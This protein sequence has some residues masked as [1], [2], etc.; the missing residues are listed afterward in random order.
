MILSMSRRIAFGCGRRGEV[1]HPWS[2]KPPWIS[3][4]CLR[5][6][7]PTAYFGVVGGG[8]LPVY[9]NHTQIVISPWV[10]FHVFIFSMS[11]MIEAINVECHY[12][13]NWFRFL[14]GDLFF[15]AAQDRKP[16]KCTASISLLK[17]R[18]YSLF[19]A[20]CH[21]I[22]NFLE[23][24]CFIS[25]KKS[26]NSSFSLIKAQGFKT[27]DCH[28]REWWWFCLCAFQVRLLWLRLLHDV[29]SRDQSWRFLSL[30]QMC[31]ISTIRSTSKIDHEDTY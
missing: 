4:E 1:F 19:V 10:Y 14:G 21:L 31:D 22:V 13:V 8:V 11:P 26:L 2:L 5:T 25:M 24:C 3:M 12:E 20:L 30:F 6:E 9:Q 18:I 7:S 27:M 23:I 16:R 29:G 15:E 28:H 17:C